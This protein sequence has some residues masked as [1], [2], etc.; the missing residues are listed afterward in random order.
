MLPYLLRENPSSYFY[1]SEGEIKQPQIK[2]SNLYL[3][4][5]ESI[6]NEDGHNF[7]VVVEY[8]IVNSSPDF[9]NA[10][11]AMICIHYIFNLA[12]SSEISA[13]MIFLQKYILSIMDDT[14]SPSKVI[15]LA[16]KLKKSI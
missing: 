9:F 8:K 1:V 15:S 12:Y 10:F 3:E 13:T 11:A 7:H 14:T 16:A 6:F 2:S 4:R 5:M